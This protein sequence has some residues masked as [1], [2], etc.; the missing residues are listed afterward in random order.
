MKLISEISKDISIIKEDVKDS[1]DNKDYFIKG[2]FMMGDTVNNNGRIYPT[3]ILEKEIDRYNNEYVKENRAFGQL[4]HED[5]SN[6]NLEKVSHLIT[7]LTQEKNAFYG[8]AKI[9]DTPT[10][11]IVKNLIDGGAK[12]GVSSRGVGSL[13]EEENDVKIVQD[14]FYIITPA[15]IVANPSVAV[16]FVDRVMES[17]DWIWENGSLKQIQLEDI[18]KEVEKVYQQKQDRQKLFEELC[19]KKFLDMLSK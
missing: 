15:D 19:Y 3:P 13:S 16:A 18:K 2:I 11:K 6:I 12:L 4:N 7:E 9:L 17:A 5:I 8:K 14:D 1:P 10:G